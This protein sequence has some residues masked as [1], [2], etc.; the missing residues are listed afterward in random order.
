MQSKVNIGLR[1]YWLELAKDKAVP[2]WRDFDPTHVRKLLPNTVVVDVSDAEP[3]F[4][5]RVIGTRVTEIAGRDATGRNLDADLYGDLLDEMI[6]TFRRCAD[7]AEPLA[8]IG[9]VH[10][11]ER[12]WLTLEHLFVPFSRKGGT[13]D[14]I[15]SSLDVLE[16]DTRLAYADQRTEKILDW[17][18]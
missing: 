18:R 5:Y 17:R 4:R 11:A 7:T 9:R 15:V 1:D 13:L 8:T 10:F 14:T 16:G 2:L 6:W 3:R 12:D